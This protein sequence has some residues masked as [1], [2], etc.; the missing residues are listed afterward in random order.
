MQQPPPPERPSRPTVSAMA[1]AQVS[2]SSRSPLT[3]AA[4][5]ALAVLGLV[6]DAEAT[7]TRERVELSRAIAAG[8]GQQL[9][10]ARQ[11]RATI[12]S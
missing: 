10:R 4:E 8:K 5:L 12:H 9:G 3:A 7:Y 2:A 1:L 6:Q 11:R